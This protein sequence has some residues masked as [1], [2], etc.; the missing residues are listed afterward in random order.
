MTGLCAIKVPKSLPA[1][2]SH[3]VEARIGILLIREVYENL[4]SFLEP[5]SQARI[6]RFYHQ[7]D[8][9]RMSNAIPH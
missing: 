6:R 7:E 1:D 9:I 5:D 2:V 4:L 8:A 3:L